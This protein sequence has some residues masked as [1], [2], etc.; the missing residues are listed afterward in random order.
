MENKRGSIPLK[1]PDEKVAMIRT[2]R[3][4]LRRWETRDR[5][6]FARI[7][8]DPRVMEFMPAPL[9][10]EQSDAMIDR[11]E[12]HFVEHG[13]GLFATELTDE[14]RLIGYVGLFVPRFK[15]HFTPC[16]EIGWRLGS[17]FWGRGLATEG[18][19]AVLEQ[20][21][22]SIGLDEIVSFTVPGN[23]RSRRVMEKL[24]M[25]RDSS[26]DFDHPNLPEGHALR[27]HVLYR[28][29]RAQWEQDRTA[30]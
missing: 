15:A 3:L 28:M 24:G 13:F 21:F 25:I 1:S 30:K 6:P 20:A 27:R 11:M 10:K 8:A 18:A 14:N 4:L 19:L 29:S 22:E 16:V 5:E 23:V 17:E 12:A 2:R 9:T 7:N 26:D